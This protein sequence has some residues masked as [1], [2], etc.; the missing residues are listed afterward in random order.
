IIQHE[1]S[2]DPAKGDET[3]GRMT[4][5]AAGGGVAANIDRWVSQFKDSAGGPI[6]DDAKQVEK[7]KIGDV[8]VH[9]VDLQGDFQDSPRGPFGPKINRPGYR[10]LAAIIP[11]SDVARQQGGGTWFI[12]LYGPKATIKAAEKSF[13]TM[14]GG[15]QL[16]PQ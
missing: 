8:T 16:A 15:V 13:A 6:D 14:V 10:M 4:I 5:M 12:K 2:V 1:F 7:K 11:L 9:V 3:G